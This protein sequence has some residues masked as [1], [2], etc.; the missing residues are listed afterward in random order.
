[1][2]PRH[3][4]AWPFDQEAFFSRSPAGSG[5]PAARAAA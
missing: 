4:L 1:V 3:L 2:D 5:C